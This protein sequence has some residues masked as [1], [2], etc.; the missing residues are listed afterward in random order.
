MAVIF[1]FREALAGFYGFDRRRG[2][3]GLR[4][5]RRGLNPS[6]GIPSSRE[7]KAG[8]AG[9]L[10]PHRGGGEHRRQWARR[11]WHA[12]RRLPIGLKVDTNA[13]IKPPEARLWHHFRDTSVAQAQVTSDRG[14]A[15]AAIAASPKIPAAREAV[16][17]TAEPSP[18]KT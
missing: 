5:G 13:P 3:L 2:A 12:D 14:D 11:L 10:A 7:R 6:A 18:T 15:A 17:L 1:Q 16:T 4:Y 9:R 8:R